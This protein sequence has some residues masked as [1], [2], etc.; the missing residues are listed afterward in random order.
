MLLYIAW[1][2]YSRKEWFCWRI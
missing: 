1:N 2:I